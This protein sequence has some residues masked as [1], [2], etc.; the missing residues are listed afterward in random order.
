MYLYGMGHKNF[1]RLSFNNYGIVVTD[2]EAQRFREMY[3]AQF[4]R[5]AL[6]HKQQ[7]ILCE[8]NGGAYNAFGRYRRL[9]AIYSED[10]YERGGAI[11]R[12]INTP[13]QST[14]SDILLGAACEIAY[15][16]QA[17]FPD[18]SAFIVGTIH[19]SIMVECKESDKE[20][21]IAKVKGIMENPKILRYFRVKLRIPLVADVA[22]GA[23]GSE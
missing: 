14:A 21:I 18:K 4:P 16:L 8:Q 22:E 1:I 17:T 13:V 11:R 19:D 6:W 15:Y 9:E 7:E 2:E 23:W 3:F 5:L 12:A 20:A 10:N